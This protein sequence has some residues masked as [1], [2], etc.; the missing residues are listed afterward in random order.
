MG[1]RNI[2]QDMLNNSN[3]TWDSCFNTVFAQQIVPHAQLPNQ[4]SILGMPPA[5]IPEAFSTM[6]H[7]DPTWNMDP[8]DLYPVTN[9]S[10]LPRAL[11]SLSPSM[12]HQ[13]LSYPGDDVLRSLVSRH[14]ISCNKEKSPH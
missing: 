3:K 8:G 2:R 5:L 12:W 6:T 11:M 4:W 9:S 10:S 14:F 1:F 7:Q 13:R